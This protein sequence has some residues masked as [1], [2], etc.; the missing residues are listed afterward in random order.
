MPIAFFAY[1]SPEL[2]TTYK[3]TMVH[4]YQHEKRNELVIPTTWMKLKGIM[5]NEKEK[6]NSLKRLPT[7]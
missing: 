6:K 7:A 1:N 5:L 3:Q 4:P 2:E